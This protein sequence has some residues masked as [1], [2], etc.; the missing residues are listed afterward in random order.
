MKLLYSD[1]IHVGRVVVQPGF[2]CTY[3]CFWYS[4][5]HYYSFT[6]VIPTVIVYDCN[7]RILLMPTVESNCACY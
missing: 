2:L 3:H 5:S 4:E 7:T 6:G 1:K